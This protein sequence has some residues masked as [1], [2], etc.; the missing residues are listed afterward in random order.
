MLQWVATK[1]DID[2]MFGLTGSFAKYIR[3]LLADG[4]GAE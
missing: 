4:V 1:C 2:N 3:P